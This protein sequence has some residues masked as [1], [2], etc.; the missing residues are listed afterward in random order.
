M[1]S[2]DHGQSLS[3]LL[4]AMHRD[5]VCLLCLGRCWLDA[6]TSCH[7]RAIGYSLASLDSE[8]RAHAVTRDALEAAELELVRVRELAPRVAAAGGA[9]VLTGNLLAEA[10]RDDRPA[11]RVIVR[12]RGEERAA[13]VAVAERS[14]SRHV[15]AGD[16][17]ESL[18]AQVPAATCPR[19]G[20]ILHH[21]EEAPRPT[22]RADLFCYQ[23]RWSHESDPS[24]RPRPL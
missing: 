2:D 12:L 13:P 4:A 8:R 24:R 18:A 15:V 14:A 5:G 7:A 20:A 11:E 9:P 1:S 23:Y 3:D 16:L 10:A 19:C 6:E 22:T 21:R 17:A